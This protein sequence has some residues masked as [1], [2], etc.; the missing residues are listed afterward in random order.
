M[1]SFTVYGKQQHN[2]LPILAKSKLG[3]ENAILNVMFETNPMDK[4]NSL[5]F[6]F[7]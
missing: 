7:H 3:K 4:V 1:H 5:I 6:V 2:L